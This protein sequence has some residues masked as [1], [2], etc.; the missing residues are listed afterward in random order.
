MGGQFSS[1]V[2]SYRTLILNGNSEVLT[3]TCSWDPTPCAELSV[4]NP[5]SSQLFGIKAAMII[6]G[7][8]MR[9][10]FDR[11]LSMCEHYDCSLRFP[12]PKELF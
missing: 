9:A 10:N 4:G 7:R 11:A 5:G 3:F 12:R 2:L 6:M 1:R 8:M